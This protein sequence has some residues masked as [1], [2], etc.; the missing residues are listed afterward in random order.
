LVG[1][2]AVVK[3]AHAELRGTERVHVMPL[4]AARYR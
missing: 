2:P 3:K 1:E 4:D